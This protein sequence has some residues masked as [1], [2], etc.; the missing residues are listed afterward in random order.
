MK[1]FYGRHSIVRS[2]YS[3]WCC[4]YRGYPIEELAEK[5]NFLEVSYLLIYGDLP[6]KVC[7]LK[8]N[9][10]FES[11]RSNLKHGAPRSCAI[12]LSMSE[13]QNSWKHSTMTLIPWVSLSGRLPFYS[14]SS[15]TSTPSAIAAMST[16]HPESNPALQG[17]QLYVENKKVRNKAIMRLLGKAPTV[18]AMSYRHR[19]GRNYN[20]PQ[21][22]LLYTE[23]FLYMLDHL[24]EENYRPN[25]KLARALD[26]L[27]IL[28]ASLLSSFQCLTLT[29]I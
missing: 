16:F 23:N 5:S 20:Q 18:A 26:I 21:N 24:S 28:H 29:L 9:L 13:W 7:L 12:Q 8:A 27:F 17:N 15:F 19:V 4:R 2:F 1:V 14:T 10:S 11:T 25:P 6:D 3:L 22:G